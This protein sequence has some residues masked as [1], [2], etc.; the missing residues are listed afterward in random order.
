MK[1]VEYLAPLGTD[2]RRRVRH[3]RVRGRVVE[4]LVQYEVQ[5]AGEWYPVVRYDTAHGF[6]HKD[7]LHPTEAADK[8]ALPFT[9]YNLALT[10][11]ENDLRKNWEKYRE[12]FLKEVHGP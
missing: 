10:Y 5:V 2:G 3:I 1:I 9:D 6:A 4:F 7:I 8:E 11:A 12:E